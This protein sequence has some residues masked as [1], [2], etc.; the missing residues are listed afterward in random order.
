ME[1]VEK[2]G[3]SPYCSMNTLIIVLIVCVSMLRLKAELLMRFIVTQIFQCRFESL[4]QSHLKDMT[5]A[6]T[7]TRTRK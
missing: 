6:Y 4:G 2:Y 7:G 3:L 1:F 5:I